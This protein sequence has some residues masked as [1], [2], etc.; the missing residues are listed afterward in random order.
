MVVLIFFPVILVKVGMYTCGC[1]CV[2]VGHWKA[3]VFFL[4][5]N[6][7]FFFRQDLLSRSSTTRIIC[8]A[9][10]VQDITGLHFSSSRIININMFFLCP[11]CFVFTFILSMNW[12]MFSCLWACILPT[13]LSLFSTWNAFN[14]QDVWNSYP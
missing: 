14:S 13:E 3:W 5:I 6:H 4:N 2:C 12:T 7:I 1:R 11:L 10:E 8:L 9:S